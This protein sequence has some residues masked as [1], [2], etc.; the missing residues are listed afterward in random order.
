MVIP[1]LTPSPL[2]AAPT[3]SPYFVEADT[4]PQKTSHWGI[5]LPICYEAVSLHVDQEMFA[6]HVCISYKVQVWEPQC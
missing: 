2:V 5:W 3:P 1:M 4:F 6:S